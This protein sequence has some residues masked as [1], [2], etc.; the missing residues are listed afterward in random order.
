[1]RPWLLE[2]WP[3]LFSRRLCNEKYVLL[4]KELTMSWSF[5]HWY[6]Y[7]FY[8]FALS[9]F[10]PV[11]FG[12]FARK[13][14]HLPLDFWHIFSKNGTFAPVKEGTFAQKIKTIMCICIKFDFLWFIG[15][16]F[17]HEHLKLVYIVDTNII[18]YNFPGCAS[19]FFLL[20]CKKKFYLY[21]VLFLYLVLGIKFIWNST[22]SVNFLLGSLDTCLLVK[23]FCP[24]GLV[25]QLW[26]F[27]EA[28][29]I[30]M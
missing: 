29:K 6:W 1:M 2:T 8:S 23:Q 11:N 21:R 18:W 9:T 12:T 22:K 5:L 4:Q 30:T 25:N 14:T 16:K 20:F 27:R 7:G 24:K 28:H 17:V 10:A 26:T 15:Y 3:T 13:M 19:H